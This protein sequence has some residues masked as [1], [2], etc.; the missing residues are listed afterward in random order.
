MPRARTMIDPSPTGRHSAL[1]VLRPRRLRLAA[2]LAIL[3]LPV[4]GLPVLG[5]AAGPAAAQ[6][7][8]KLGTSAPAPSANSA[9]AACGAS[10]YHAA[11]SEIRASRY[12]AV[13]AARE[14]AGAP[15]ASLPGRL[16][17]NPAAVPRG[18]EARRALAAANQLAR[19]GNR[20]AW[21]A[22]NDSRWIIKEVS[23]EL[24]RYLAQDETEFLCGGVPDYLKTMRSYLARAG[25]DPAALDAL[26]TAQA[27]IASSSV[28]ATLDALRP[29]PLPTPAPAIR[30]MPAS[31]GLRPAVG[32]ATRG[33][34]AEQP[35]AAP[36]AG[37]AGNA[38]ISDQ[39]QP[40]LDAQ[41]TGGTTP[42]TT[43]DASSPVEDPD[44][45]PLTEPQ[46]VALATDA[47]RLAALDALVEAARA[48]GALPQDGT[49]IAA[50][51]TAALATPPDATSGGATPSGTV[52]TDDGTAEERCSGGCSR[53]APSFMARGRKSGTSPCA[54]GSS[55]LS[56]RSRSSTISRTA[57]PRARIP[58]PPRSPASL[59]PS[60]RPIGR[61]AAAAPTDRVTTNATGSA[62]LSHRRFGRAM[63]SRRRPD[64]RRGPGAPAGAC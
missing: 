7:V 43:T 17:F 14:D 42:A 61:T 6:S 35:A 58:F 12:P 8:V 62:E 46:P 29:V 16:I 2:G 41:P 38:S 15:D 33:T 57:R 34:A 1:G 9:D 20:P 4:L 31:A 26:K 30:S 53:S 59:T 44:L 19:S 40:A 51:Q 11:L 24:G 37:A 55:T 47:E 36:P 25:G 27:G 45:P 18:G 23:N 63:I 22:S 50:R 54:A 13:K 60:P 56:R 39:P 49:G 52:V 5:L 28:L 3:G 32:L 21:M 64:A 48:S 10:K